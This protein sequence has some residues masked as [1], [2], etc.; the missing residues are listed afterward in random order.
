MHLR[1]EQTAEQS[2]G[3]SIHTEL[4]R[5]YLDGTIPS[6][7]SSI[8]AIDAKLIPAWDSDGLLRCE[9][10]HDYDLGIMAAGIPVKGRIDLIWT[11]EG[12]PST[13]IYD[14]KSRGNLRYALSDEEVVNNPQ[15]LVYGQFAFSEYECV[16][17]VSLQHVYLHKTSAAVK[18]RGG[19][20][21]REVL[22]EKYVALVERPTLEMIK[23]ATADKFTDVPT[24]GKVR[25][26]FGKTP[27]EAYGGCPY[28]ERCFGKKESV[29]MFDGLPDDTN[30]T[31]PATARLILPEQDTAGTLE[32]YVD[33]APLKGVTGVSSI[34]DVIAER[35]RPICEAKGV[36]DVREIKFGEG[37]A[38]LIASFKREPIFG[39]Y[40]IG[41][42]GLAGVVLDGLIASATKVVRGFR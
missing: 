8:H 30:S 2:V 19:G 42:T 16:D 14:F 20:L 5:Y 41:S 1:Q 6:T 33:C 23:V 4:E 24:C 12:A 39:I 36:Q 27:C 35:A 3:E 22:N 18:V 31:A 37:T 40:T 15:M 11:R 26:A 32:L 25:D 34:E 10:P 28:F 17:H 38:A 21:G 7:Y 29:G 9:H 13:L